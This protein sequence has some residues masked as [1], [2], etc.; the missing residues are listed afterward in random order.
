MHELRLAQQLDP[1]VGHT[2][3]VDLYSHIGLEEQTTKTLE[4]ALKIDPN[5]DE[6]K[7]VY[8]NALLISARPDEALEA[9]KR[10]FNREPDVRYL[11]EKR[12]LKQA[13]AQ[14]EAEYKSDPDAVWKFVYQFLLKALN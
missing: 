10:F 4:Q 9:S 12:M 1:N 7:S 13:E 5:N 11:V 8:I 6:A 2:E 3:L 14:T